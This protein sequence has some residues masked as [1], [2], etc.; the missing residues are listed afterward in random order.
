M[1]TVVTRKLPLIIAWQFPA[2]PDNVLFDIRCGKLWL[3]VCT[4]ES[5]WGEHAKEENKK[6]N[7]SWGDH[8]FSEFQQGDIVISESRILFKLIFSVQPTLCIFC[9]FV[10]LDQSNP[11]SFSLCL[12]LASEYE[13]AILR[14]Y[15]QTSVNIRRETKILAAN[16]HF[17]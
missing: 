4:W 14:T 8:E 16:W 15:S 13:T 10:C 6:M 7:Q 11:E 2:F 17:P 1:I 12:F 3:L 5:P 9:L